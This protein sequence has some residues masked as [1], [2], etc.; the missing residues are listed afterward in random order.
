MALFIVDVEADGPAPGLYSMV[1]FG[2]VRIQRGPLDC[3][4]HGRVAP[5]SEQWD[6]QA[7]AVSG[8]SRDEHLAH[9][10]AADEMRRFAQWL[11]ENNVGERPVFI[12]D[13]PAFDWQF[14]NYYCHAFLGHNPFGHS[15]RRIGDLFAGLT[16]DF[17]ATSAWKRLRKTRHTHHPV[18]DARGNAEALITMADTYGLKNFVALEQGRERSA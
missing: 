14:I 2:V 18:D 16:K 9:P 4:F 1:S 15:A 11:A 13:N 10:P 12:S 17:R 5:I 8:I 7:L 6:P 3:T